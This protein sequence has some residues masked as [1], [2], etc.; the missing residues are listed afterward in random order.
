[1]II[2]VVAWY[3]PVHS[4]VLLLE[5]RMIR[6]SKDCTFAIFLCWAAIELIIFAAVVGPNDTASIK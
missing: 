6:G 1:M 5:I 3:E 4:N 2:S